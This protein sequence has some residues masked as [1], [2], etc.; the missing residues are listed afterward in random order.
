MAGLFSSIGYKT[1]TLNQLI[2]IDQGRQERSAYLVPELDKVYHLVKQETLWEKVRKFF[3]RDK[4]VVNMYYNVYVYNV[5]SP[6]GSVHRVFIEMQPNFNKTYF[7]DNIAKVYCTC[8]DFKFRYA[9]ELKMRDNL[10]RNR[11]IDMELGIAIQ[12]EPT[13][14]TKNSSLGSHMCKHVYAAI[15]HL[16]SHYNEIMNNL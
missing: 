16:S 4:T 8:A 7:F 14:K 2:Q 10:F 15:N 13:E 1:L 5:S 11:R 9:W 12:Q 3:T 6:S